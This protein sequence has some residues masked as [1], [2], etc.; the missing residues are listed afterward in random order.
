MCDSDEVSCVLY[1][2][3]SLVNNQILIEMRL[4]IKSTGMT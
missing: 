1:F 3:F 2:Y 4:N